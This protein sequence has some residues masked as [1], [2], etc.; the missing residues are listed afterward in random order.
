MVV[1]SRMLQSRGEKFWK[2]S[3]FQVTYLKSCEEAEI[4]FAER[5][6]STWRQV[7]ERHTRLALEKITILTLN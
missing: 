7:A 5:R 2:R 6:E 1:S 4:E 3:N